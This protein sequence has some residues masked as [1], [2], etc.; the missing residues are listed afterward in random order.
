MPSKIWERIRR[1][2]KVAKPLFFEYEISPHRALLA[3]SGVNAAYT[4]ANHDTS[5]TTA[6]QLSQDASQELTSASRGKTVGT[7]I[8]FKQVRLQGKVNPPR[9]PIHVETAL[10]GRALGQP[11]GYRSGVGSRIRDDGYVEAE[12]A[13]GVRKYTSLAEFELDIA[14][15]AKC[16]NQ[17]DR[18][19]TTTTRSHRDVDPTS[20]RSLKSQSPKSHEMASAPY[21]PLLPY[22]AF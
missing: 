9:P 10:I 13:E 16:P 5:E 15:P 14:A 11:T 6:R 4:T 22:I 8:P 18:W 3:K 2:V 19:L 12:F 1:R 7:F 20:Q 21:L 17:P